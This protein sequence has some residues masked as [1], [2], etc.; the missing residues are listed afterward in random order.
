LTAV[1]LAKAGV[2]GPRD[3]LI[4]RYGYF[5]LYEQGLY[6]LA[7]ISQLGTRWQI[8]RLSQKPYPTGRLTHGVVDGLARLMAE[9]GFEADAV[10]AVTVE[11]PPLIC[12]LVGRPAI[13]Q[14]STTY[15][16]LCLAFV[17]GVFLA[18]GRVDVPD[19]M[20]PEMLSDPRVHH[21]AGMVSVVQDTNA[22][23]NALNPQTVRVRLTG[24]QEHAITLP[25]VFGHP[26]A[27]LS[28]EQQRDKFR[29]CCSFGRHPLPEE[30]VARLIAMVDDL[31]NL[32]DVGDLVAATV[33]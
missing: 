11:A 4:G 33:P 22:D 15:A 14:P 18:R 21:F 28:P 24:G 29:R 25:V 30:R 5:E 26:E 27:P 32:A 9:H 6:D 7:P 19:F 1:D 3:F 17:A 10:E 31:D 23:E 13:A 2:E 16:K 20:G 8:T 12:R